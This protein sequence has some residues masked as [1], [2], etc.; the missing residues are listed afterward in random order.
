MVL[1]PGTRLGPYE[2]LAQLGQGGMGEVYRATDT[3]LAR[4]VALKVLSPALTGDAEYMARFTREAHIL[5]SFNHPNIAL[6][7]G[8]EDTGAVRALVMELVEGRNLADCIAAGSLGMEEALLIARQI[9]EALEAAHEKGVVH[10]DLKPANI[11]LTPEGVVKV[12]DFGLAKQAES[13]T[14]SGDHALSLTVR[15]TQAGVVM[16]TA[17]YMAPEQAAAKPAD[18]RADIWAFGVVL[19]EMLCRKP[20]F[21]GESIAHTLADVLRAEIDVKKLPADTPAPIR[22][23]IA[24][25][26]ERDVKKRLQAIGEARI[27]IEKY[28]ADPQ[29]A[30]AP[31][32]AV[33]SPAPHSRRRWLLLSAVAG[34]SSVIAIALATIHFREKPPVERVLRY[35]V[36]PPDKSTIDTFAISPDAR[37]L[38]MAAL[39]QGKRRLFVRALDT[40]VSQ[41]LNGTEDA[42]YPFWSPDSRTIGFFAG[43]KLKKI[44][45]DGGPAQILCDAADGRGGTWN[46]EGVIVFAPSNRLGLQRVSSL[47]GVPV[48]LAKPVEGAIHRFP[49]FLPD[50]RRYLFLSNLG[51]TPK[52]GI[53]AGSLDG[54]PPVKVMSDVSSPLFVPPPQGSRHGYLLFQ[55]Q[56]TLMAQPV[57]MDTLQP[58]GELFPVAE[59]VGIANRNFVQASISANGVL[60]YWTS[61]VFREL[62]QLAWI[63][64]EGKALG[65]VGSR[66]STRDLALSPDGKMLAVSRRDESAGSNSDIWLHEFA[67]GVETRFTFSPG[68]DGFAVWSTDGKQIFYNSSVQGEGIYRKETSGA[69]VEEKLLAA[70]ASNMKSPLD[71]SRDGRNLLYQDFSTNLDLWVLP[72]E[73]ERKPIP[74]LHSTF[75]ETQGRFSPDGKWVAYASDESGRYEIYVQPFPS[76]ASKWKVSLDGGEFPLWRGDGRELY[77]VTPERKMMAAAV[78]AGTGAQAAFEVSAPQALFDAPLHIRPAGVPLYPYAVTA[79]GKRFLM[80]TRLTDQSETALTVVV[81]WLGAVK[82]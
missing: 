77:F 78:K 44:A 56:R 24:R 34:I 73:G 27:A 13:R 21:S 53:Y 45:V 62:G 75:N 16:G 37:Y 63:D 17:G 42:R 28:L 8:F 4:T 72:L 2:I 22:D 46:R 38:A 20:L 81:N 7:Y 58:S 55:R 74:F 9:A 50:G 49:V 35:D 3:K 36:S 64:R 1:E 57:D 69:G 66:A 65:K 6:I 70:S 23:L 54:T 31:S 41:T 67:R 5:A 15:A 59:Q 18:R 29:A 51:E 26:L 19:W 30:A 48:A 11:M 60:V 32:T 12:L 33:A 71:W 52:E 68:Q 79:D 43:G 25:C 76:G 47:G 80:D 40:L 82:K 61:G 39:V 14:S 10:R